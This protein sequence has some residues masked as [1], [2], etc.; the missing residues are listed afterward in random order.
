LLKPRRR[1]A[2]ST[3][4]DLRPNKGMKLTKLSAAWLPEWTCRLMPAPAAGMDAGTASQLIPGV[5]PTLRRAA[6]VS[7][8]GRG[9]GARCARSGRNGCAVSTGPDRPISQ[10]PMAMRRGAGGAILPSHNT[11]DWNG[12]HGRTATVDVRSIL[13]AY[14]SRIAR[15]GAASLALPAKQARRATPSR[16]ALVQRVA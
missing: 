16:A 1:P 15:G 13:A 9:R 11:A 4:S 12:E 10:A 3:R 6:R 14:G 5:L 8:P 2:V 7:R